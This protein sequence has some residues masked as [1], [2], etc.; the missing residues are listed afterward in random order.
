MKEIV[1]CFNGR[2]SN[3]ICGFYS[4]AEANEFLHQLWNGPDGD[5]S[6]K[7]PTINPNREKILVFDTADEALRHFKIRKR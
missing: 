5:L 3:T 4:A 6:L 2:L 1:L 7:I